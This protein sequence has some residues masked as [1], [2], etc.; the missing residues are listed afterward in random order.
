MLPETRAA[1]AMVDAFPSTLS[2]DCT[3]QTFLATDGLVTT[4]P[5]RSTIV[6]SIDFDRLPVYFEALSLMYRVSTRSAAS[7]RTAQDLDAIRRHQ[8]AY[9]RAV[10]RSDVSGM[11]GANRDFHV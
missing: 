1:L 9:E 5:N 2:T 7:R 10:E 6:A 11:I 4:L 3:Q 8:A